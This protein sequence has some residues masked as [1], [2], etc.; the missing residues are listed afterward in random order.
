MT[1]TAMPKNETE[2]V[3]KRRP[4]RLIAFI[5]VLVIAAA[6]GW[7]LVLA[8][9]KDPN[10]APKPG[11]VQAIDSQQ[12]NLSDGHYLR[13]GIAL[14]L[15]KDGGEEVEAPKAQD[16]TID[17]FS[18]LSMADLASSANREK[19]KNQLLVLLKSLYEGK[20]MGLYFNEFV[21][22]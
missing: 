5:V 10:A 22:Q 17:V 13:V 19:Y 20:V 15:T 12:I 16:A 4:V 6:G 18:G 3:S 11:V 8:P 7:F 14:Q 1:V 21:T 2:A 9:S